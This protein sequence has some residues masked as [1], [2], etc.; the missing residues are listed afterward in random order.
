MCLGYSYLFI[1]KQLLKHN[2]LGRAVLNHRIKEEHLSGDTLDLGSAKGKGYDKIIGRNPDDQ[3]VFSDNKLGGVQVDYETDRLP[4]ADGEF[5]DVL[6]FN[7][8]EHLYNPKNVL[9]EIR[10]IKKELSLIHISEPTRPY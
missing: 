9:R 1:V 5:Q 2:T 8:L 10:R 4:F 6:L 7:V 3:Y